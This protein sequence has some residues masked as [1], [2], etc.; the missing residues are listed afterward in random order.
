[1]TDILVTIRGTGTNYVLAHREAKQI[2][3]CDPRLDDVIDD[4]WI[5]TYRDPYLVA[6]TWVNRCEQAEID[7]TWYPAWDYYAAEVLPR[8]VEI[9]RVEDFTGPVI[10]GWGD[11]T[12]KDAYLCGDMQTYFDIVPEK[13]VDHALNLTTDLR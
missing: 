12:A 2:H 11:T 5:T 7:A 8:A 13:M 3:V 10:K 4:D 6:A 1:M 9:L